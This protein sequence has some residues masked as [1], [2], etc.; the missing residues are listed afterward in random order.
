MCPGL[1]SKGG[2]PP[3]GKVDTAVAI[4]CEGKVN[5]LGIGI[6]KMSPEEM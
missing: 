5:C 3:K 2:I 4:M 1:T 6:I